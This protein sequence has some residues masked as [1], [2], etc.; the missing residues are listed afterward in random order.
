[1]TQLQ[2]RLLFRVSIL[3][4]LIVAVAWHI[5]VAPAAD[6][7]T[8]ILRAVVVLFACWR[9]ARIAIA[10]RKLR[11]VR[12]AAAR[13]ILEIRKKVYSDEIHQYRV[14]TLDDFPHLD[15]SFY[16]MC[17]TWFES[18]G[19]R[20]AGDLE[21]ATLTR[22]FPKTRSVQRFCLN[23]DG[24]IMGCCFH[25]IFPP[26]RGQT[27][28]RTA[29]R[30]VLDTEFSDGTYVSTNNGQRDG[31]ATYPT[32]YPGILNQALP[33]NTPPEQLIAAHRESVGRK[34]ASSPG[35]SATRCRD[36][37]DIIQIQHRAQAIKSQHKQSIDWGAERE[38]RAGRPLTENERALAEEMRRLKQRDAS[39]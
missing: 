35:I 12:T 5:H 15:R 32:Q 17:R 10:Y 25:A 34:L 27:A 1:M 31:V 24:S 28:S 30:I 9:L 4:A 21:D 7:G 13:N 14:V 33:V 11:M 16:D 18:Q 36:I 19:F 29:R 38:A 22:L 39:G 23:E 37:E 8:W 3:L 26:R 6:S 2:Q 20:F